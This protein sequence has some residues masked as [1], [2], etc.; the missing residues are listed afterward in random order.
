MVEA[1][2]SKSTRVVPRDDRV[3]SA[4]TFLDAGIDPM[5]VPG[6]YSSRLARFRP[7]QGSQSIL[8][9]CS[10]LSAHSGFAAW[11]LVAVRT[12]EGVNGSYGLHSTNTSENSK[13][14]GTL[15]RAKTKKTTKKR[16]FTC[17]RQKLTTRNSTCYRSISS[18]DPWSPLIN[19]P[20]DK[21]SVP[22]SL[23]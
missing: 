14:Y 23:N 17:T 18:T 19:W 21:M 8:W 5:I 20:H 6:H 2:T 12:K 10:R 4:Y 22:P 16:R 11:T 13:E 1:K 9:G 7:N 3:D 15:F